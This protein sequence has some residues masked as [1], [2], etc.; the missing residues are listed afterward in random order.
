[1]LRRETLARRDVGSS[2][3]S[4]ADET[5][6]DYRSGKSECFD[7]GASQQVDRRTSISRLPAHRQRDDNHR[8]RGDSH[9][10]RTLYT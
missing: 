4:N 2:V 9:F 6:V 1:M 10:V 5:A 7:L 3:C 8:E